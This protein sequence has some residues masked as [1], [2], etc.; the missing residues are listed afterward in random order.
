MK[1]RILVL[2]LATLL[3]ATPSAPASVTAP[4]GGATPGVVKPDLV[5][6]GIAKMGTAV[7]VFVQNQ[8][9]AASPA[10]KLWTKVAVYAP[11]PPEL[12]L[13]TDIP[14]LAPG[15]K[16]MCIVPFGGLTQQPNPHLDITSRADSTGI[17]VESNELN[18]SKTVLL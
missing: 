15:K 16:A 2:A 13:T 5:I 3:A 8:G 7:F 6:T 1:S 10:C 17:V 12:A 18:N 9:V 14:A 11:D 4:G